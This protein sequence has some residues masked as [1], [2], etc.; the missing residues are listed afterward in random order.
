MLKK[1]D[2]ILALLPLPILLI[3]LIF[4]INFVI[5]ITIG[6]LIFI[7][8]VFM[9]IYSVLTT[10]NKRSKNYWFFIIFLMRFL[11]IGVIIYIIFR[12]IRVD[13]LAL[14][15]GIMGASFIVLTLLSRRAIIIARETRIYK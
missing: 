14:M 4:N 10:M 8:A 9:L 13:L 5:G 6:Y 12:F 2:I 15:F 3:S 11:I 1:W 7:L